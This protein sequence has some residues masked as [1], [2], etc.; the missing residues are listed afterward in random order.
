MNK[1]LLLILLVIIIVVALVAYM[2]WHSPSPTVAITDVHVTE[3]GM[4]FL[5]NITVTDVSNL[6]TWAINL[7]WDP[8]IIKITTGDPAGLKPLN[9]QEKY[10]VYE[11]PFLKAVRETGTFQVREIDNEHGRINKLS[12]GYELAG[13]TASGSGVLVTINFTCVSVGTTTIK[14][15][16][17]SFEYPGQ[18]FLEDSTGNEIPHVDKDGKVT[19]S[20]S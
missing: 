15:T 2:F 7:T 19:D 5:V 9:A 13:E 12:C 16:G 10:N 20:G 3:P 4:T 17:P 14:I 11:G 18:S 8:T 1:K 6:K